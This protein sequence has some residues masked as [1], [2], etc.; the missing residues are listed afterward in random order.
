MPL[1][2]GGR[3]VDDPWRRL[4]ADEAIPASGAVLLPFARFQAERAA[5]AGRADP[6]GVLLA[7]NEP[8]EA[9]AGDLDRLSLVALEFP[10][11]TDG[12]AYSTAR[13][14]R[15]R[16]GWR[17]ELRAV[18]DVELEHLAFMERCGFDAFE[19]ASSDPERDWQIAQADFSLWYQPAADRRPT[20]I[21]RRH[22]S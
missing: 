5:L 12:R 3:R 13:I 4:G 1:L 6:V 2:K 14:L 16:Y 17:G 19:L 7:P 9:I 8:P 10:K 15:E 21:E 11:F 18:G 20:V 22:R